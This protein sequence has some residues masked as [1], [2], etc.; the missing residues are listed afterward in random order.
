VSKPLSPTRADRLLRIIKRNAEKMRDI[1]MWNLVIEDK[2]FQGDSIV[3]DGKTLANFGLCSYLSLGD[4]PR[5]KD[6]AIDAVEQLRA[7]G[8]PGVT[9]CSASSEATQVAERADMV[10]DGPEGVVRFLRDLVAVLSA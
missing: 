4:D 6:A 1:G 5:V 8:I 10:V 7:R 2:E 9:I 3:L